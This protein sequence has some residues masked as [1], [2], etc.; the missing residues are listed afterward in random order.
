MSKLVTSEVCKCVH[1]HHHHHY[2]LCI[3]G[4]LFLGAFI[5][6]TLDQ[7][8]IIL[9][10]LV[11][12]PKRVTESMAGIF[13]LDLLELQGGLWTWIITLGFFYKA[14]GIG[15]KL[16]RSRKQMWDLTVW[17][18]DIPHPTSNFCLAETEQDPEGP[19]WGQILCVAPIS[20]LQ[21]KGFSLLDLPWVP[22][23]RFKQ[24]LIGEGRGCRDKGGAAKKQYDKLGWVRVKGSDM[25]TLKVCICYFQNQ[26]H[27]GWI[28]MGFFSTWFYYILISFYWSRVALQCCVSFCC[29]AKWITYVPS[30]LDSLPI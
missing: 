21:N 16:S 30:F 1:H 18:K 27:L 28:D 6:Q 29:T 22:K 10:P 15:A 24:L 23:G 26:G 14:S 20:Y 17:G 12:H 2:L 19:S 4:P 9:W 25:E 7:D 11:I 5:S 8:F 13:C 3:L